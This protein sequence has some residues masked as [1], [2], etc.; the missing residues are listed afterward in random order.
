MKVNFLLLLSFPAILFAQKKDS[1]KTTKFQ[2]GFGI[3]NAYY[4]RI[5]LNDKWNKINSQIVEYDIGD[6]N[7]KGLN[8]NYSTNDIKL[9]LDFQYLLS[10]KKSKFLFSPRLSYNYGEGLN[11]HQTWLKSTSYRRDTLSSSQTGEQYFL[12]SNHNE[13]YNLS[14]FSKA[15]QVKLGLNFDYQLSK[16]FLLYT[17]FE[18]GFQFLVNTQIRE[19]YTSSYNI[20]EFNSSNQNFYVG[21]SNLDKSITTQAKEF[22]TP[23]INVYSYALPIGIKFRL[24]KK[25]NFFQN[26][27]CSYELNLNQ[28]HYK[29]GNS[30]QIKKPQQSHLLRL[31]YEF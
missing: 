24:S 22:S 19:Y 31:I 13:M 12:D 2:L 30:L 27:L 3:E 15:H 14:F 8:S 4:N 20:E 18:F 23:K 9:N 17:G 29:F 16:Q 10:I 25:E 21:F 7:F 11:A 6:T 26:F 1:L 5:D 28:I